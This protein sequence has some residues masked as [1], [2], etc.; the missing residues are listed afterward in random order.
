MP[1][2]FHRSCA[3]VAVPLLAMACALLASAGARADF[4]DCAAPG[5]LA[6]VDDRM[7]GVALA[8]DEAVRFTI[9]TPGGPRQVRIV[10]S[11]ADMSPDLPGFIADI[12]DGVEQAAAALRG[13]GQGTTANITIWAA[14][15]PQ[16]RDGE[17]LVYAETLPLA[18]ASSEC[19]VA[20]FP[21]RNVAFTTAHE[22]FHC[23]QFAT[24]GTRTNAVASTWWVEG[25][26]QWF[27]ELAV[28]GTDESAWDVGIFDAVSPETALT[29]MGEEAMVFFVWLDQTFGSSMAMALM[30]SMPF[31][32]GEAAQQDALAA[33]LPEVDFLRF[34]E[35][36]LD[37]EIRMPGGAPIPS[38]PFHG[39][40]YVFNDSREH[41]IEAGRFVAVRFQLQLACGT[42]TLE[43]RDE[44]GSW[45]ISIDRGPW[46]ALPESASIPGPD[47]A[48]WRSAAFGTGAD[49]FTVTVEASRNP[50]RQ[51]E[52]ALASIGP[53]HPAACLVGTWT[54]AS[55]GY[56]AM[57][58][59]RLR[60]SGMFE[61]ISYPDMES[62]LVINADGGYEM[63]GPA[64]GYDASVSTPGGD[65]FVGIGTLAM[66]SGGH[67]SVD[68][69][70]LY[71][72]EADSLA[73]I[74]LTIIDPDGN[75]ERI[76]DSGGPDSGP[77]VRERAFTCSER[78]LTLIEAV[79]FMADVV[80]EYTR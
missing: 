1:V 79:P 50:C 78:A 32:G 24:F 35:A 54:L 63:P 69:D 53:D 37:H 45:E 66:Q 36:Y 5:Y 29:A 41:R 59:E 44:D 15:L 62:V 42:W 51:C 12:R 8:C 72:C 30:R 43:R 39:D 68:A 31:S 21:G 16:Y 20:L 40:I 76:T 6:G 13:I 47:P 77:L 58:E 25:S 60:A 67:W 26:A 61:S 33:F 56:G 19:V 73:D 10:Y 4:A 28:P 71:L 80:W 75:E 7:A 14:H 48:L 27:A 22:F 11:T 3:R 23:V 70:R 74:D 18:G 64:E 49:G 65:L 2:Q 34:V 52:S 57:I 17:F 38:A 46:Q 55:G 9:E